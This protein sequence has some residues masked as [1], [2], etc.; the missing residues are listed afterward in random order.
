MSRPRKPI[1]PDVARL[2]TRIAAFRASHPKHSRLPA[3][4]WQDV[5]GLAQQ[6][7]IAA[8][9]RATGIGYATVKHRCE[10]RAVPVAETAA[11]E[12]PFVE[13]RASQVFGAAPPTAASTGA[14]LELTDGQGARMLIRL[15][16]AEPTPSDLVPLLAA[17]WGRGR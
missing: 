9:S 6:H 15:G 16:S 3:A 2:R 1:T 8:V 5:V 7:G 11:V 4:L 12:A 13:L 17:F 14:E 10:A